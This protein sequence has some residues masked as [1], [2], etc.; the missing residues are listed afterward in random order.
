RP[1]GSG[2]GARRHAREHAGEKTVQIRALLRRERRIF[3]E[4]GN[5]VRGTHWGKDQGPRLN[6]QGSTK[7]PSLSTH[8]AVQLDFVVGESL[9][10]GT[11]SLDIRRFTPRTSPAT[12][13]P[14]GGA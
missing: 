9:F 14:C 8:P 12:A 4:G 5:E 10:I 11:G 6:V 1:G 2:C 3:R 7:L 13:S